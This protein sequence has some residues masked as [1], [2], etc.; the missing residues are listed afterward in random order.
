M[1]STVIGTNPVA[2]PLEELEEEL[3]EEDELLDDDDVLD[4]DV[5]LLLE[6]LLEEDELLDVD[7]LLLVEPE[8]LSLPEEPPPQAAKADTSN[9]SMA[10]FTGEC[11]LII[12]FGKDMTTPIF[13]GLEE[14]ETC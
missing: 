10:I 1:P 9:A 3:L 5:L 12:L 13:F 4:V 11:L 6:E 7:E 14:R 2:L 8:G